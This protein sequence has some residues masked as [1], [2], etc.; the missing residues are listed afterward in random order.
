MDFNTF[1]IQ[2]ERTLLFL[3][4]YYGQVE[5]MWYPFNPTSRD[6]NVH[7]V[8]MYTVFHDVVFCALRGFS[9]SK[10]DPAASGIWECH[11]CH[12]GVVI[13]GSYKNIHGETV[14]A[15]P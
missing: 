12:E 13:P 9:K 11:D 6:D 2:Q 1:L 5:I 3:L 15:C 7:F 14:K 4:L 8:V 10:R